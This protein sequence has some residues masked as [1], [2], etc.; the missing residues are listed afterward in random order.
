ML[1][2]SNVSAIEIDHTANIQL[3]Y[4]GTSWTVSRNGKKLPANGQRVQTFLKTLQSPQR[5]TPIGKTREAKAVYLLDEEHR[6]EVSITLESYAKTIKFYVSPLF[7]AADSCYLMFPGSNTI[8]KAQFQLAYYFSGKETSWLDLRL[9]PEIKA[10]DV[11]QFSIQGFY[12]EYTVQ[13]TFTRDAGDWKHDSVIKLSSSQA[14]ES[15]LQSI[16]SS[17]ANDFGDIKDMHDRKELVLITLELGNGTTKQLRVYETA[18]AGAFICF[19]SDRLDPLVGSL[20]T[21]ETLLRKPEA[22]E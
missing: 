11:Q 19:A 12:G 4:S 14:V 18:E 5:L 17:S 20:Y 22:L 13:G 9:F 8:Y 3:E 6:I 21:L 2:R 10:R 7:E 1:F 16:V 15:W